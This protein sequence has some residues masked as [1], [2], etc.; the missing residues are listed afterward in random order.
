MG[1]S[2][3]RCSDTVSKHLTFPAVDTIQGS[4]FSPPTRDSTS[5]LDALR[6]A[7]CSS[8]SPDRADATPGVPSSA[9]E[10]T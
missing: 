9:T 6:A 7:R 4:T 2:A 10:E 3:W 5:S 8:R 1:W